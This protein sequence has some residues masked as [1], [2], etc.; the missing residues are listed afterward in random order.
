MKS[1]LEICLFLAAMLAIFATPTLAAEADAEGE[2]EGEGGAG[3]LIA[4]P[5]ALVFSTILAK[6]LY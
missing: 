3:Q 1:S 2:A 5:L 6:L 4:T